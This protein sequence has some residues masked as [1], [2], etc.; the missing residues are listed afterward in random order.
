[1]HAQE[2][3]RRKLAG[4][5]HDLIGQKL[6]ALGINLEFVRQRMPQSGA[7][8]IAS[9]LHQMATLLEETIGSIRQVMS[10]LRPQALDEHGLSAALY[11]YAAAFEARTGLRVQVIGAEGRLPLAHEVAI[12][13]FRIA[14]EALTNAAKHS[15]ASRALVRVCKSREQVELIV[16]DDGR[17]FPKERGPRPRQGGGWGLPMM[18]ERAEAVGGRLRVERA[19]RRTRIIVEVPLEHAD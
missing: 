5:L 15:G 6:T 2:A 4:D 18:R 3:E 11:Q 7:A 1:V 10:D 17:G 19:E 16:E 8:T 12:A 14:Q 9:R 13:L